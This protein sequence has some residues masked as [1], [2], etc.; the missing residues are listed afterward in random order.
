MT[1]CRSAGGG[2]GGGGRG[3]CMTNNDDGCIKKHDKGEGLGV[4]RIP[5]NS[6]TSLMDEPSDAVNK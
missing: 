2:G 4:E 6:M 3:V 5:Q 1:S